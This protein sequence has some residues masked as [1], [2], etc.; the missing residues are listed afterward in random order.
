MHRPVSRP[1]A[2]LLLASLA[3]AC[4]DGPPGSSPPPKPTPDASPDLPTSDAKAPDVTDLDAPDVTTDLDAP[5]VATDLDAPDV[6]TDAQ[7][8]AAADAAPPCESD[9]ECTDPS[10]PRCVMGRCARC[11]SSDDCPRGQHCDATRNTCDTGCATDTD[12]RRGADDAGTG[13]VSRCDT[14]RGQCVECSTDDECPVRTICSEGACV[15]GCNERRGCSVGES[16]CRNACSDLTRDT[17]NCGACG[18]RCDAPNATTSCAAGRCALD[19]CN[20]GYADCDGTIATG[21]EVRLDSDARNCGRCGSACPDVSNATVACAAGRCGFSCNAG[22]ADCDGNGAN[23]CER[24]LDADPGACGRCGNACPTPAG[25]Q[26]ILC[27]SGACGFSCRPGLGNCDGDAS[28]GCEADVQTSIAHCGACDNACPARPNTTPTCAAGRCG[29]RCAAGWGDCDGDASNGCEVDLTAS[30][31]HCGRCGNLCVVSGGT[32]ACAAGACT[33]ASCGGDFAD[34][35]GNA[36]NGCETDLRASASHCGMC[37]NPCPLRPHTVSTCD[38]RVCGAR[39]E[40]GFADCD[41]NPSNGCEVDTRSAVGN[42]GA[43]G[44]A[45]SVANG[46][47]GCSAGAC[48]LAT[49]NTGFGDCDRLASNG[50]ETDLTRSAANCG[51]CGVRGTEVCDGRDNTCDGRVDE[52]CPTGL[53]G[54]DAI[55]ATSPTYGSGAGTT[56]DLSCPAGTFASG[57]TGRL[58]SGY[59]QSQWEFRCV[60]PRLVEN[61]S[62]T[63]YAYSIAWD[64]AGTAGPAGVATGTT[65]TFDCPAGSVI[66]RVS[67][68][69]FASLIGQ[70]TWECASWSVTG[71]AASGW[72]VTRTVT[73]TASYGRALGSLANYVCPDSAGGNASAV[74]SAFGRVNSPYIS[75]VA[76]RCSSPSVTVR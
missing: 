27:G 16:C 71:S 3:T 42:C 54:L 10:L 48:T 64:A 34:C 56:Y 25:A 26:S 7:P 33:V 39:C 18:T 37:N 17:A 65:Y 13:P 24:N 55:S 58:Y 30:V 6:A 15:P 2:I 66:H 51:A 59:Y 68:Y 22:Y 72:R 53:A 20:A 11:A 45:C 44:R 4:F 47:A 36:A 57:V 50:C 23:G 62:A 63:P 73:R 21:C 8:D 74:R 60:R 31:E 49:C 52:G 67:P 43:C 1:A 12:C 32:A 35:D 61:T 41:G 76:L 9:R 69:W 5:D 70:V 14:A 40:T 38:A 29:F 46:T 19:T 75:A 28:N